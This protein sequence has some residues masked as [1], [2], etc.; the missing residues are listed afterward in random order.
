[1]AMYEEARQ[2]VPKD[3]LLEFQ[4]QQGWGPL[5]EFL[6][7][8]VP[9]TPFPHI[10]ESAE[11][12]ERARLITKHVLMRGAKRCLS[13]LGSLVAVAVAVGYLIKVRRL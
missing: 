9:D 11:F 10:N 13:I 6:G 2:M 5:C 1:M 12:E 3:R 7:K 4:L 8:E